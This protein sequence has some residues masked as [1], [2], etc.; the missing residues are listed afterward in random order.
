LEC[1]RICVDNR[2]LGFSPR[3]TKRMLDGIGH[4]LPPNNHTK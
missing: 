1:S 4:L 3:A 2:Q